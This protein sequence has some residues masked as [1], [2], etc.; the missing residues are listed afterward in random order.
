MPRTVR[1]CDN[2]M[3]S[4]FKKSCPP[5]NIKLTVVGDKAVGKTSLLKTYCQGK[6]PEGQYVSTVFPFIADEDYVYSRSV[7][8]SGIPL[9]MALWDRVYN[10]MDDDNMRSLQYDQTDVFLLC[11]S[12]VDVDSF[13]NVVHIWKPEIQRNCP[14]TPFILVGLKTDLRKNSGNSQGI[15]RV[16]T[17]SMGLDMAEKLEAVTYVECSAKKRAGL[18]EV[19]VAAVQTAMHAPPRKSKKKKSCPCWTRLR[20]LIKSL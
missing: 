7:N 13:R 6:F 14:K 11:F 10:R 12:V 18:R 17:R 8:Y 3:F 5:R 1:G 15:Q 2:E 20:G 9:L 16:I 4:I 19:F